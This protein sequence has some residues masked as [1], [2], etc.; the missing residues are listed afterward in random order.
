MDKF[1]YIIVLPNLSTLKMRGTTNHSSG[2]GA[3]FAKSCLTLVTP[4]TVAC[5]APLSLE[6]SRQEYL[7]GLPFSSPGDLPNPSIKPVSL[8]LAGRFFTTKLSGKPS[9]EVYSMNWFTF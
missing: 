8:A 9:Y 3:L 4:W 2:G 5:Q 1:Y 7:S 6:F